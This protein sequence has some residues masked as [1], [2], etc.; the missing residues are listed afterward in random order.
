MEVDNGEKKIYNYKTQAF[1]F[2]SKSLNHYL[3]KIHELFLGWPHSDPDEFPSVTNFQF[4]IYLLHKMN[5]STKLV[6]SIK[7]STAQQLHYLV[8]IKSYKIIKQS[9]KK[10]VKIGIRAPKK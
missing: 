9:Y 3:R 4:P 2:T 6:S 1:H 5:K 7:T 10:I 8:Y